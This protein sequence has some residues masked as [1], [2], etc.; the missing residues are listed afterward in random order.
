MDKEITGNGKE[1]ATD[2]GIKDNR[3][4][5]IK[6]SKGA[7]SQISLN[8]GI[9]RQVEIDGIGMGVLSDGTAFLNGRGLARL[10]GIVHKQIQNISNEWK[11]DA[12]TPR[13]AKIKEI[14]LSHGEQPN[15]PYIVLDQ[16]SGNFYAYPDMVCLAILEYYAFDAGTNIKEAAKKN[17][18]LLAGKALREFIYAQVGYDPT[19]SLPTV[20]KIF[21]DRVSL[22]YNSIPKG[23]F[24][25]F[26]EIAD[27]IITLGQSGIHIDENFVPDISVGITWAKYWA[28]NN[29]DSTYGQRIKFD[30]NY[31]DYFPQSESNPQPAWCYPEKS[32]G[33]FR[34]WLREVYVGEGKFRNYLEGQTKKGQLP[35]SFAQLAIA[36]YGG[37]DE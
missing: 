17:Y 14:L 22:T 36:A 27:M 11:S 3:I 16:R 15:S 8:L 10:C 18:R 20:W 6:P 33:E 31:P 4:V 23:Y 34:R 5:T 30:H 32:L 35:A 1:G 29:C 21:H 9:Q 12:P 37:K 19:N 2:N 25:I 7:V 13:V 24:G 28:E 26:K